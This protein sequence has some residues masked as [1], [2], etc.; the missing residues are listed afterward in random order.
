[1][2]NWCTNTVELT[3]EDPAMIERARKAFD[4]GALLQEFFPCPQDL[5]DTVAGYMG[6]DKA[7]AHN[8]QMARNIELYGYKDWYDWKVANWGTK[9]DV[10]ADCCKADTIDGGIS[11]NFDSAW[12]PPTGAY[13]KLVEMGFG[14]KAYYY[15]PGMAFVGKWEDGVDDYYEYGGESSETVRNVIGEELDDMF[16]ISEEMAQYEAEENED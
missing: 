7:A 5:L 11:V 3:H 14:V 16:N 6:E 4:E 12:S 15:E 2:P 10:G 9:W 13:E 8:A 1:M